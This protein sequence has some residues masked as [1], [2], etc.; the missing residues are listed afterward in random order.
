MKKLILF[1]STTLLCIA[2]TA[3]ATPLKAPCGPTA[4]LTD[5]CGNA[6]P[7]NKPGETKQVTFALPSSISSTTNNQF[8]V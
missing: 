7:I 1:G 8:P 5:P 4:G 3:C 2:L 6:K